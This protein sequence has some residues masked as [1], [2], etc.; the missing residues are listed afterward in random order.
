MLRIILTASILSA[1]S[2]GAYQFFSQPEP[3]NASMT[4]SC[5][6]P[7]PCPPACPKDSGDQSGGN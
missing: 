2:A 6:I 7:P 1:M 4:A 5:C 3:K